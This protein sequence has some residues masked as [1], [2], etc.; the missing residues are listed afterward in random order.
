M[1]SPPGVRVGR[2]RARLLPERALHLQVVRAGRARLRRRELAVA[3]A[4]HRRR[5]RGARG[6][7]QVPSFLLAFI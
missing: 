7:F 6:C 3:A 5:H 4:R 1:A 2:G